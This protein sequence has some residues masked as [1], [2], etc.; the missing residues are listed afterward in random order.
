MSFLKNLALLWIMIAMVTITPS[1]IA[2]G[3]TIKQITENGDL[4]GAVPRG[5][6]YSP[7]GKRVT[8]LKASAEDA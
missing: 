1:A 3:L 5:L 7:D 6:K 8:F 2:A 4:A